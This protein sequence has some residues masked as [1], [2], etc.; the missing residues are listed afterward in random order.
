MGKLNGMNLG[1]TNTVAGSK[2]GETAMG[3]KDT[4][5]IVCSKCGSNLFDQALMLRKVSALM[6]GT[7]QPGILPI[8]VFCCHECGAPV[9]ELLPQELK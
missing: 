2:L 5:G 1:A 3:I 4:E 6:T 8:P 7:G 9:E